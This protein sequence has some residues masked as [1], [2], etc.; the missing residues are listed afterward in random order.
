ML[1]RLYGTRNIATGSAGVQD[2]EKALLS[3]IVQKLNDL[4]TG[5]L[6]D[7]DQ[8]SYAMAVKGKLLDNE[9]LLNQAANNKKEQFSTSPTLTKAVLAAIMDAFETHAEM[10]KQALESQVVQ[11]G[12]KDALLGPGQ[13]YE[14]L[15]ARAA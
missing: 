12:L 4:F 5:D 10:S 6:S 14:A 11:D 15:R 1:E 2:K 13:L 8:L 7:N 9:V 3:L